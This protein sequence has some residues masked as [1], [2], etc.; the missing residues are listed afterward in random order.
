MNSS[1]LQLRKLIFANRSSEKP[2]RYVVM[3]LYRRYVTIFRDILP[4]FRAMHRPIMVKYR[5]A[6]EGLYRVGLSK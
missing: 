4:S 6:N 3:L 2:P 5:P 1:N